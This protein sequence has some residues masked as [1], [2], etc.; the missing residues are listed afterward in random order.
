MPQDGWT[1]Q[2][3]P[4][5]WQ[6]Q[7]LDAWHANSSSGIVQ[8]VTGGGKTIFAEMCMLE[9]VA[10]VP[11]GLIIIVVPT[12]TLLDQ[13]YVSLREELGVASDDI[14]TYSGESRPSAPK[15]INLMVLN[16]ARKCVAQISTG[17]QTM[18]IVDECHRAGSTENAKALR[19]MHQATLGMSA[20]PKREYDSGLVEHLV[21]ALGPVIYEYDYNQAAADGVVASFDL[22]NVAIDLLPDEEKEYRKLSQRI[23]AAMQNVDGSPFEDPRVKRLLQQR[24]RVSAQA[25]LRVPAAAA[26]A[27]RHRTDKIL[28]FH[29]QIEAAESL[30]RLLEAR[31][32]SA[33]TY[34]SK[35]GAAVRRDNLRLFRKG[36]FDVLVSCRAL[37]EGTNIPE[38]SVA[39]IAS[40]TASG[41]QRIQRMG[42]VLRPAKGKDLARIYTI[43]ATEQEEQ[44]LAREARTLVGAS[45]I[46]WQRIRAN[47]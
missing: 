12:L 22:I 14:A 37:D 8:V 44:R 29:E 6:H 16:T 43:Y 4:R 25:A 38:T 32:V 30:H 26:I 41:R 9:F 46:S 40:S 42:R 39:I 2:Y 17:V 23:G 7:A 15:R 28:V 10:A 21:P 11:S 45:G 3:E 5:D 1:L 24:A 20:T 33:T 36:V 19:G 34:H 27:L 31:G 35:I 47:G 18:L 13:W